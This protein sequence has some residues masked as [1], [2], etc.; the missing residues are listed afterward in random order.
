MLN[1]SVRS[2]HSGSPDP[3]LPENAACPCVLQVF[4]VLPRLKDQHPPTPPVWF[5]RP[6]EPLY[7][8]IRDGDG[9][10]W[11]T[12]CQVNEFMLK[13]RASTRGG[14]MSV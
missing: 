3:P 10:A 14:S 6:L 11:A 4:R 12:T 1:N 7:K 8:Q 5:P 9:L 2:E 13:L